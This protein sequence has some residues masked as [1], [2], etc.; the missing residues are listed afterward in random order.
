MNFLG[1]FSQLFFGDYLAVEKMDLALSVG[2]ESWIV[3]HHAYGCAFPMQ[4]LEQ[5][6]YRFAIAGIE[7]SGRFVRQQDRRIARQCSSHSHTLLLTA[8]ACDSASPFPA[9]T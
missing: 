4:V 7:V 8:A 6:H 9:D 5:F 2:R 1:Q 3:R